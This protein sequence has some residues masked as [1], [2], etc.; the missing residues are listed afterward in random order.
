MRILI[1]ILHPAHVHFYRH[2]RTEMLAR[3][4]DVLIT[5]RKKDV[6]ID[7]LDELAIPHEV[8]S[9]QRTGTIGLGAELVSRSAR[10]MAVARRFRPTVMTGIMG[11]A[12]APVGR[13]LRIPSVIFY[14]TEAATR[15]NAFV[16]PL[17]TF[18]CTP[19]SYRGPV[20]GNQVTYPG[21]HELAYLHPNR[22]QPN[23]A[24]LD[25]YGV[26]PPYALVRF[27]SWQAS[28]DAG[29]TGLDTAAKLELVTRLSD[30]TNVV[31]S[32][33]GDLP[34]QLEPLRLQ[35]PVAGIHD[36][37]ALAALVIGDSATMVSEA[38]VLGTPSIL[39][40]PLQAGVQINQATYGLLSLFDPGQVEDAWEAAVAFLENGPPPGARDRLLRDKI[41]VTDWMSDF[42]ENPSFER[43]SP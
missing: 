2:F 30:R 21:Y 24:H 19:D 35:G 15:T 38:A 10:L 13:L 12:I 41:D 4:H 36:V 14:D 17:A 6:T 9:A 40:S 29:H 39:V 28:H 18:V 31:I 23:A 43:N 42:F 25:D 7:L 1:D 27:V 16:Y 11:P 26:A 37:L 32:A 5:A 33:E 8:L 22:F 34:P 3:G 20:K